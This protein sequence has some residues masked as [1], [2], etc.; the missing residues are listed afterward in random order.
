MRRVVFAA[1]AAFAL[2]AGDLARGTESG[3]GR[4]TE[5]SV[6]PIGANTQANIAANSQ[7]DE[8]F[9]PLGNM[10]NDDLGSRAK[11]MT[12]K[13]IIW[14]PAETDVSIRPGWFYH[15]TEDG[16]V[17]TPARLMDLYF[18][19]VGRNSVLLLNIPPDREG[20]ISQAD[21]KSLEGWRRD[22]DA[23]FSTNL[24]A[25]AVIRSPNGRG[26]IKMLDGDNATNWTTTGHDTAAT[27]DFEL[28]GPKVFDVLLLQENIRIGQRV[29]KW[30]LEYKDGRDWK[31]V[32]EGTTIGYKRLLR[33]PPV[34][35]GEVRLRILS[36]RLNP[37]I[38]E[39]GFYKLSE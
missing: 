10:M 34:T 26:A 17:K 28:T 25:G 33:F 18:S 20:L 4:L 12:A 23:T 7:K 9:A 5:W 15:P 31:T 32:T 37:T 13:G 19:S 14:Y 22:L 2:F 24:A 6:M 35:A 8:T 16:K 21:V 3:D 39:F 11:L 1:V 38:A 36:S 27:V 29:E 30:V